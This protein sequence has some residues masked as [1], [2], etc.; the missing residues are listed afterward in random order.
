MDLTRPFA[1]MVGAVASKLEARLTALLGHPAE[2]RPGFKSLLPRGLLLPRHTRIVAARV[3]RVPARATVR[4]AGSENTQENSAEQ[5]Y[6]AT[7]RY[8]SRVATGMG[9]PVGSARDS[10]RERTTAR[11]GDGLPWS[12][13]GEGRS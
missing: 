6:P 11:R 12:W 13:G 9:E 10:T 2:L 3:A 8:W 5:P 1:G 4:T 7:T